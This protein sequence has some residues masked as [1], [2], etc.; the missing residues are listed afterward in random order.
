MFAAGFYLATGWMIDG[1]EA[2]RPDGRDAEM[3]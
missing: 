3:A 1:L 2:M